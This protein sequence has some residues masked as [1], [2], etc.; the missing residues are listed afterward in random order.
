[1]FDGFHNDQTLKADDIL[2]DMHALFRRGVI[3]RQRGY[4]RLL[5][6]LAACE[7]AAFL[8]MFM[9]TGAPHVDTGSSG[10]SSVARG[11][12]RCFSLLGHILLSTR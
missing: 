4:D 1:L 6:A 9:P 11:H 10:M 2:S 5:D 12:R 7:P 8:S 3:L